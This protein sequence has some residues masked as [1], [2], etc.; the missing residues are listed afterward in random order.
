MRNESFYKILSVPQMAKSLKLGK[1]KIPQKLREDVWDTYMKSSDWQ[2]CSLCGK[3]NIR[4]GSTNGWDCGH[5]IPESRGGLT[6]IENLRPICKG[7]NASIATKDMMEYCSH[8][9]GS[10]QRLSLV[11]TLIPASVPVSILESEPIPVPVPVP[12]LELEPISVS[13]QMSINAS[14]D[15]YFRKCIF[16]ILYGFKCCKR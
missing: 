8:Y 13:A 7:C 15:T 1:K 4:L 9:P 10:L 3:G 11:P 5:V 12:I 16:F 6:I 2:P 14:Q